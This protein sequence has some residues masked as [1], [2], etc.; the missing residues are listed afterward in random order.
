M[1]FTVITKRGKTLVF[2]IKAC[3]EIF[4][5]AYGGV[6]FSDEILTNLVENDLTNTME[7]L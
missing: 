2:N 4:L 7:V 3:A 5:Q 6:M 1:R